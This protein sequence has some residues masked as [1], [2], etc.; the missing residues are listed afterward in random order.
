MIWRVG[1]GL[2]LVWVLG[3][4]WFAGW[5]PEPAPM[6]RTDA[7]IVPTGGAGRIALLSQNLAYP[8]IEV[9]TDEIEVLGRV[10]WKSGRL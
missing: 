8:P 5:L 2:L 9:A 7:V 4:I 1:L 10:V 6:E 3:F